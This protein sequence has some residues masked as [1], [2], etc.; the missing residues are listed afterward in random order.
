MSGK[1]ST[2]QDVA[3]DFDEAIDRLVAGQPNDRRLKRLASEGRLKIN[4]STVAREAKRS[5]SLIA[6]AKCAYPAQRARIIALHSSEDLAA[7][8]S[9]SAVISRLKGDIAKLKNQLQVSL[10][11]QAEQFL[12]RERASRDRD[13]AIEEADRW[14]TEAKRLASLHDGV[15]ILRST[16]KEKVDD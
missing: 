10:E 2:H 9:A 12:I 11:S 4:P 6:H 16:S 1:R 7:P 15:S 14:R 13:R 3:K 5:R 8:R